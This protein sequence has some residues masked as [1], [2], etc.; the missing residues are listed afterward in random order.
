MITDPLSISKISYNYFRDWTYDKLDISTLKLGSKLISIESMGFQCAKIK[1]LDLS[2]CFN[3]KFIDEHAFQNCASLE[4]VILPSHISTLPR[5]AF[6]GL[7]N[8]ISVT[9]SN[10]INFYDNTFE[11]CDRLEFI[12]ISPEFQ[13]KK[14]DLSL[15][16]VLNI[17]EYNR[18]RSGIIIG[19]DKLYT[20]IWSFTD[21]RFYFTKKITTEYPNDLIHFVHCFSHS[22]HISNENICVIDR[23]NY[24][25]YIAIN[26]EKF[27]YSSLNPIFLT[28]RRSSDCI[29][30]DNIQE[31]A[32]E[33]LRN[34]SYIELKPFNIVLSSIVETVQQLDVDNLINSYKTSITGRTI[35]KI[36]GDDTHYETRYRG[37]FY[38]DAY[39]ETLLPSFY[40][41]TR[42]RAYTSNWGPQSSELKQI[43]YEDEKQRRYARENYDK[44]KH[45]LFLIDNYFDEITEKRKILESRLR[46]SLAKAV[47]KIFF[48]SK[49]MGSILVQKMNSYIQFL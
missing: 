22:Y 18:G 31:D 12:Q 10:L 6:F 19:S 1:V 15:Y 25:K 20:Y 32:I 45:I 41:S 34:K 48:D 5:Y 21:F 3:L 47:F 23:K 29:N 46:I 33:I 37:S 16:K 7:R 27:N 4:R 9:G 28:R 39:I 26:I 14:L 2:E 24:Y 30:L 13:R 42:Q 40:S 11:K 38:K 17:D 8:L 44:N 43:D 36:G 35:P 49:L